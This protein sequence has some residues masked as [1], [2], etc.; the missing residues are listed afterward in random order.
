MQLS[1]GRICRL[2]RGYQ[3]KLKTPRDL[4]TSLSHEVFYK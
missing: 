3:Y 4:G 2:D 1:F